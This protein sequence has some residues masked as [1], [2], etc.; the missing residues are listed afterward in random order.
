MPGPKG[1]IGGPRGGTKPTRS[2]PQGCPSQGE[3]G[4]P[5]ASTRHWPVAGSRR[6]LSGRAGFLPV[7]GSSRVFLSWLSS[8]HSCAPS[9]QKAPGRRGRTQGPGRACQS[10]KPRPAPSCRPRRPAPVVYA[11]SCGAEPSSQD[12]DARSCGAKFSSQDGDAC[13]HPRIDFHPHTATVPGARTVQQRL[14][15]APGVQHG[16]SAC[17][18]P[19][20]HHYRRL[21]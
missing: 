21:W 5:A 8:R 16:A 20:R 13:A 11:R 10:V 3:G 19:S 2:V 4:F 7:L 17:R 1:S 12:G 14:S 9:A 6:T 18:R 15:G